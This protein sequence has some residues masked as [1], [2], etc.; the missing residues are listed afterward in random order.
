VPYNKPDVYDK[1]NIAFDTFA[2]NCADMCYRQT[3]VFTLSPLWLLG[4][5]T[6]YGDAKIKFLL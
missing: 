1:T 3:S 6:S 4:M 5:E 2:A